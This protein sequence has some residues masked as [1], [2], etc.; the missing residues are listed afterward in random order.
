[1]PD[2]FLL[3]GIDG[4]ATKV[5]GWS[6]SAE[7]K[8]TFSLG[9]YHAEQSYRELSGYIDDFESVN[10]Q[11]QLD[12]FQ[13]A[14]IKPTQEE[15]QHGKTYTRSAAQVIIDIAERSGYQK[16][17]VGI[18]MPG[19]KTHDGRG[20][21][22]MANGPRNI[23]YCN[24]VE[25]ILKDHK[26]ELVK[27]IAH[28]GSD[29]FYCGLGEEYAKEGRFRPVENAYYLGGGTGTADALKLR[30]RLVS[31]DDIKS[32]FVKTW[33][34]QN[35]AGLSLEKCASA[36]GIQELYSQYSGTDL[37]ALDRQGIFPP[38][39]REAALEG[40][41]PALQTF[42]TLTTNLAA[43][44]YE[45]AT[46][47]YS[48]WQGQFGFVNPNKPQPESDHPYQGLLLNAII[49]GQRLG[50]LFRAAEGDDIL[51]KPFFN[52]LTDLIVHSDDLDK[53]AKLHYCPDGHFL[54]SL[55]KT[56]K[57]REAPALGAG[58]DAHLSWGK[59]D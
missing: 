47:L 56:S 59:A 11:Q 8:D 9:K 51:W 28:L 37:N 12:E 29:A 39:I 38:Q 54:K 42:Q 17:L 43:L 45:R 31:L 19:L 57:L 25:A 6:V 48:G 1:M 35:E 33:E 2:D 13:S 50:E 36:K 21:A 20:I 32:W 3:I 26:I 10:I 34:M 53:T 16:V 24:H 18:G 49:I 27:P 46:T 41:K 40:E 58:I 5:S 23:H 55:L 7:S 4:G 14:D 44:I 22:V 30:G 52:R 15:V